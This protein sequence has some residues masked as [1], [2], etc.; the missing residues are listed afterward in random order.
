MEEARSHRRCPRP[1]SG[2]DVAVLAA[3]VGNRTICIN[4]DDDGRDDDPSY[5]KSLIVPA[6]CERG[7]YLLAKLSRALEMVRCLS[8]VEVVI[9]DAGGSQRWYASI[10]SCIGAMRGPHVAGSFD[11]IK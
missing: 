5:R 6:Y 1:P 3:S 8:R 10:G 2:D 9:V 7:A 11:E 4:R